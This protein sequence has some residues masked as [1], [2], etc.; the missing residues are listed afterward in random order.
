LLEPHVNKVDLI[1]VSVGCEAF[2]AHQWRDVR[3]LARRNGV[4]V[5]LPARGTDDGHREDDD[6]G[7]RHPNDTAAPRRW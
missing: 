3:G 4:L 7:N 1:G 5:E 2:H 6:K